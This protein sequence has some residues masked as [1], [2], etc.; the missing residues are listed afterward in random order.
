MTLSPQAKQRACDLANERNNLRGNDRWEA[1]QVNDRTS[2]SLM[3][4]AEYIQT[5]S[6]A[7]KD[8]HCIDDLDQFILPDDPDPLAEALD[9]LRGDVRH[10]IYTA[11]MFAQTVENAIKSRG[12][13]IVW[14]EE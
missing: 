4:L 12:G 7:V 3:T 10:G 5:V 6:D 13:K 11:E 2:P 14:G 8:F 9:Q 1:H